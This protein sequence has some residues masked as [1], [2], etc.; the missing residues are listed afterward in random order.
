MKK[1]S[2]KLSFNFNKYVAVIIAL[3][4]GLT[5]WYLI[6]SNSDKNISATDSAGLYSYEYPENWVVKPY[7]W[8]SCCEGPEFAE[9]DWSVESKP[10]TLSPV[11]NEDVVIN[12]SM[13]KY[14]DYWESFDA[15][16]ASVEE[17]YFAETIF[18]GKREDG[19]D[20]IFSKVSYLGP[21]DAKVES[22][23]DYRYFFDNSASVLSIEF[24]EKYHHDWYLVNNID[25]TIYTSDAVQIANSIKFLSN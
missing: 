9:P 13:Q 17:D 11:N 23:T 16:K 25:Y 3:L 20:A 8:T 7:I 14:G 4:I 24:R 1:K 6:I 22:F 18:L 2:K 5:A 12:I 10:I 19:H 15:I 21:P